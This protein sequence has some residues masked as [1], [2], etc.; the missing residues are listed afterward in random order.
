M[1]LIGAAVFVYAKVDHYLNDWAGPPLSTADAAQIDQA[2]CGQL[3]QLYY[4]YAPN[5][6]SVRNA[7]EAWDRILDRRGRLRCAWKP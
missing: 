3:H 2:D 7:R 1:V 6:D 5:A 4:D